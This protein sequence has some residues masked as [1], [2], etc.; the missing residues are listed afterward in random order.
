MVCP[1]EWMDEYMDGCW[2]ATKI[3]NKKGQMSQTHLQEKPAARAKSEG[4][5]IEA[6]AAE[7]KVVWNL[8]PGNDSIGN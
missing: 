4:Q 2:H 7:M 5:I 8:G 6:E 3:T 1:L